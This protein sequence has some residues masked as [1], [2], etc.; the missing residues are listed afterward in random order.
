MDVGERLLAKREVSRFLSVLPVGCTC[1]C[2]R[3]CHVQPIYEQRKSKTHDSTR[4]A[5][6]KGRGG[7]S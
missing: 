6:F 5:H 3:S 1:Y 7:M 2:A 4:I